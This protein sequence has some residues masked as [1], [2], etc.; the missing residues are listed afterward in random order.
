[1][2][3]LHIQGR[4]TLSGEVRI[5]GAKNAALP[6]LAATL[7]TDEEVCLRNVP[8]VEDV[9]TTCRLL[10]HLGVDV[11]RSEARTVRTRGAATPDTEATYELLKTM[12]AG[13]LVL[14]PMLARCGRARVSLP[15]GC[16][17]GAR[18]VDRHLAAFEQ[19]GA[20][21]QM[22]EGYVE[23][24]CDRLRGAEVDFEVPT[25]GGTENCMM[26]ATLA[27]GTTVIRNAAGEPEVED[28]AR[29]LSAMGAR[30]EGAGTDTIRI[31]GVDALGGA[32]HHVIA[33][34][35]EAG[36]YLIAGALV[37]DDLR[38]VETRPGDLG[39][40][41]AA[42]EASGVPISVRDDTI[43]V[44][45]PTGPITAVDISTQ[46]F[47][48][49]P[50]DMQ[51]QFMVLMTQ[52]N[53]RS[54]IRETIFENRFMH[55]PELARMGARIR[56]DGNVAFVLGPT[57]LGGAR[58]MATDL[59][60]SASLVLAGLAAEGETIV[61]RLYHLDRGYEKLIDKLGRVGATVER[62]RE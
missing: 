24:Q 6:E 56:I 53:G 58:V 52:A 50:T 25:V 40:V 2:L 12:R 34:R 26:A 20:T 62:I 11:D 19:L 4:R 14:G 49:F 10:E 46:P 45:R 9:A 37:G 55:V 1:M 22:E 27:E 39:A 23:A 44:S 30:I 8:E 17:I 21:L 5:G 41:I 43:V 7:L 31:E 51:A 15:G 33:D 42:V 61:D 47:P 28:L 59:R 3:K 16:A 57:S 29:L 54:M 35:I 32:D 18:P 36:T 48:G 13:F 60:A 38:L